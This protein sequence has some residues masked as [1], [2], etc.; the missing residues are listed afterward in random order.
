MQLVLLIYPQV[1]SKNNNKKTLQKLQTESEAK[2]MTIIITAHNEESHIREK[3]QNTIE[4]VEYCK[5]K[6][7]IHIDIV[8]ASDGSTDQTNSIVCE[9]A[10][11]DKT[12]NIQL[13]KLELPSG[14]EFAQQHALKQA[15]G[16]IIVFTDT[17]VSITPDSLFELSNYFRDPLIGAV[18]TMDVVEGRLQTNSGEGIYVKYEMWIRSV[19]S[20]FGSLVGLSGSFFAIRRYLTTNIRTDLPSDFS[21]LLNTTKQRLRSVHAINVVHTYKA[22]KTEEQEFSRKVRTILRGITT[23]FSVREVLNPFNYGF[24]SWQILS[25]KLCRWLAPIFGIFTFLG[26]F[27][28]ASKSFVFLCFTILSA[29]VL[30]LASTGFI[31]PTVRKYF[32]IKIPLFF[33]ISNTAIL[34]AWFYFIS[35]K[36]T[37]RWEPTKR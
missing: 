11:R 20:T 36:R 27:M 24:F 35:G 34:L 22:V 17:K 29:L 6:K 4:A 18:S 28:L 1:A 14:K 19:E 37:V 12:Q 3:I 23:L 15:K 21:L 26:S 7:H 8:V 13:A 5:T 16:D 2:S 30:I 31:I 9:F 25:H 33:V 32:F 10:I